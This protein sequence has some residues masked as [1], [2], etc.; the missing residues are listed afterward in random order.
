MNKVIVLLLCLGLTGC[1]MTVSSIRKYELPTDYK[2]EMEDILNHFKDKV[3]LHNR[4]SIEIISEKEMNQLEKTGSPHIKQKD[5]TGLS[6]IYFD[7][8]FIKYLYK[9]PYIYVYRKLYLVCVVAHEICHKE[10]DLPDNPVDTHLQVDYKAI[11]MVKQ[12]GIEWFEYSWALAS[13]ENYMGIRSTGGEWQRLAAILFNAGVAYTT[14]ILYEENDLSQ[15]A[16][17]INDSLGRTDRGWLQRRSSRWR[18]YFDKK[19]VWDFPDEHKVAF[20]KN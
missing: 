7:D 16:I 9:E 11:D 6:T 8:L 18:K 1:A 2:S 4:Y 19:E 5:P 12:F 14:G 13:A 17:M 10:Y 20:N 15:R 3:P